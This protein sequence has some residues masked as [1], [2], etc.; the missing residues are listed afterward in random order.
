[1]LLHVAEGKS[2]RQGMGNSALHLANDGRCG[3]NSPLSESSRQAT[4]R[5]T[6]HPGEPLCEP[7]SIEIALVH[8]DKDSLA[9]MLRST[10]QQGEAHFTPVG[11]T[12]TRMALVDDELML[13]QINSD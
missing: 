10:L 11:I 4:L 5:T 6:A 12:S 2:S 1:M 9:E 3:R 7:H 13:A 8:D